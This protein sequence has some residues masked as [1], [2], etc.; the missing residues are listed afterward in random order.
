M[1]FLT[2]GLIGFGIGVLFITMTLYFNANDSI[3]KNPEI[4]LS[5]WYGIKIPEKNTYSIGE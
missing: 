1:K 2:S 3:K 5:T 4:T